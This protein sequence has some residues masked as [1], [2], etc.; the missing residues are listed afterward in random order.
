MY[1]YQE[2]TLEELFW[3]LLDQ[4]LI[5][6]EC[7]I[8]MPPYHWAA[9]LMLS[10][11]QGNQDFHDGKS[12]HTPSHQLQNFCSCFFSWIYFCFSWLTVTR[13]LTLGRARFKSEHEWGPNNNSVGETPVC[14]EE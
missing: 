11:F 3:W 7:V 2:V 13:E 6:V 9:K 1:I 4:K 8:Y 12:Q 5:A 14:H 10:I